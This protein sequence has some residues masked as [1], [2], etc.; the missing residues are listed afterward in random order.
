MQPSGDFDFEKMEN[1]DV[2]GINSHIIDPFALN[3]FWK[4]CSGLAAVRQPIL[5]EIA[6]IYGDLLIC[7]GGGGEGAASTST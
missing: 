5:D 4:K 2:D 1:D 7:F 3:M 6:E